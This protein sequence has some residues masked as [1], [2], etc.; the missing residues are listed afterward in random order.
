MGPETKRGP[1]P[2]RYFAAQYSQESPGSNRLT[3][4]LAN[5]PPPLLLRRGA[6]R[7]QKPCL[8][9]IPALEG[10]A[11]RRAL[12]LPAA[13]CG[14]LSLVHTSKFTTNRRRIRRSARG[15]LRVCSNVPGGQSSTAHAGSRLGRTRLEPVPPARN[16]SRKRPPHPA[17]RLTTLIRRP[18][19]RDGIKGL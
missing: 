4:D 11:E 19:E 1:I 17:P 2:A 14:R 15:A 12:S 16:V 8:I 9:S 13:P 3:A 10:R 5:A 7:R 18:F 6:R